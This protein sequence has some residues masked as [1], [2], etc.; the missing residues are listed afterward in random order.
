MKKQFYEELL[1]DV[2]R[3]FDRRREERRSYELQWRLNMNFL[4]GNQY[5]EISPRGEIEDVG[6]QY[7]WQEREVYNHI[8]PIMETRIAKLTRVDADVSVRPSSND[9][10]DINTARLSTKILKA[11]SEE[12]NLKALRAEA[13][14]WSEVCGTVFYKVGWDNSTGRTIGVKNK[15]TIKEGDV[16]ISVCPPYEIYPDSLN[17]AKVS[18]CR[19]IIHAKA[20]DIA[21]IK[22]IWGEDVTAEEVDVFSMD[23]SDV[24]GGLGYTATVPK[25]S[26]SKKSN[27]AIVIERYTAPTKDRPLGRLTIVASDKILYDG[28]LPYI[29]GVGGERTF[30]FVR[31]TSVLIPGAF[32]G[33]SVIE[34]S[35]P[36]QRAFNAIKNRKHEF[37]NRISMGVLAVEDG[38]VDTDNLEEEGLSPG[39]ILIYRQGST[40]PRLLD[41]GSLPN[42]FLYEEERLLKEFTSISGVSETMQYSSVPT[43]NASGKAINLLLEQDDTRMI[44]SADSIRSAMKELSSQILRLY[45]QFAGGTRLKR[46]SGENGDIEVFYFSRADIDV[47]YIVFETGAEALYSPES[48]RNTLIEMYKMGLLHDEN[49]NLTPRAKSKLVEAL[50]F[51][52]P[53]LATD[54]TEVHHKVAVSENM[55]LL[56]GDGATVNE[57]DDHKLHIEEHTKALI[58]HRDNEA[59]DRHIREHIAYQDINS[60][61]EI[62]NEQQ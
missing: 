41:G 35:I 57:F 56:R 21:Y 27:H 25:M 55:S 24:L 33:V 9:D 58:S 19:S 60:V 32:F 31:Q 50:G 4:L 29:N 62:Q 44:G 18:D 42:D 39:K 40:P 1:Q 47:D 49:G 17:C 30:P 34:R 37:I 16:Q 46:H 26:S 61:K 6:K 13:N 43:L 12:K 36:V 48:R 15:K 10:E 23:N 20:Y 51:S 52:L 2:H 8:A 59:I 7:F 45:K 5:T 38:S 53:D 28:D 11:V 54:V 14:A 22:D 3:D